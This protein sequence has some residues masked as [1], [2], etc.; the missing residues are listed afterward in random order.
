MAPHGLFE[1]TTVELQNWGEGSLSSLLRLA[2]LSSVGR[3]VS[4]DWQAR[5][6]VGDRM[7]AR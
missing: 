2:H 6:S 4:E 1:Y 3:S 7:F 5:E